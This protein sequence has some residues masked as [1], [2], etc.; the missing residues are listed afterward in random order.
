[1]VHLQPD[2]AV[3]GG[4][5]GLEFRAHGESLQQVFT[6]VE[7]HPQ[8]FHDGY[9]HDGGACAYQFARLGEYLGHLAVRLGYEAGLADV[10]LH[11]GHGAFG[12]FHKGGGCGL[13]LAL[14][15]VHSH[16]ILCLGGLLRGAGGIALGGHL[17]QLLG[18][19]HSLVVQVL[20]AF[21]R[22]LGYFQPCLCFLPQLVGGL[23]LFLAGAF[24]RFG[25]LCL[26]GGLCRTRLL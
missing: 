23:Y 19:H 26:C 2:V 17:V 14:G 16:V 1:M 22:F 9:V 21:V 20:D 5:V 15:A 11:F 12:T 10:R 25:V 13:V 7:G 18:G 3:E 8:V 24:Q 6:H 4:R